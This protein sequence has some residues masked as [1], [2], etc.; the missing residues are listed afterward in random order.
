M[1][2]ISFGHK[3]VNFGQND[4]KFQH[5][6]WYD[7][8]KKFCRRRPSWISRWP[9]IDVSIFQSLRRCTE[10]TNWVRRM[11]DGLFERY[12]SKLKHDR[13]TF[14]NFGI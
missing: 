3:N 11:V 14:T 2:N 4:A 6:S 7:K 13:A 9:L 10:I 12:N 8:I 5:K 1:P